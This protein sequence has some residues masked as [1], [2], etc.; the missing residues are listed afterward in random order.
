MSTY[1]RLKDNVL[2]RGWDKLPFCVVHSRTKQV[3]FVSKSMMRTL[4][5]C[6]GSWDFESIFCAGE[7]A[8]NAAELLELGIIEACAPESGIAPERGIAPEC[9]PK[10]GAA[11][12]RAPERAP[13]SGI[14]PERAPESG[15]A[16][17]G[18]ASERAPECATEIGT[19]PERATERGIAPE[20]SYRLYSNRFIQ[21][22]HWSITGRCNYRCQHC[23]MS[24]PDARYGELSHEAVM[25]IVRQIAE[26]GIFRVSLTG[27]E[28]LLR[29]DF[30]DIAGEL[31]RRDIA[32]TQL[33]TN[34]SLLTA[35]ILDSLRDM[36]QHPTVIMSFDGVGCHDWLRGVPGAEA[37]ANSALAL[38]AEKGFRAHAQ[39]VLHRENV[40]SLR[41]TVN[42]LAAAGCKSMRIGRVND[43]GDWVRNS[44]GRTLS[45]D[46]CRTAFLDYLPRYYEDGMPLQI[47][48]SGM[49]AASPEQPDWYSLPPGCEDGDDPNRL[50]F[51][52]ARSTMQLYADGRP[53]IC[54]DFGPDFV[55]APPVVSD[56]PACPTMPL[57]DQ[58]T[59]GSPYLQLFDRRCGELHRANDD[60]AACPY[61]R[62][63]GGGCRAAAR[64][65]GGSLLSKD[66]DT[67]SF[68][69]GGWA[70]KVVQ[71]MRRIRPEAMSPVSNDPRFSG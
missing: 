70:Q 64:Q 53:A 65:A 19:A 24:A 20:Q 71:T 37:A 38:C 35:E 58:L 6:D 33:Y 8:E 2:L 28:P 4:E 47:V 63:C 66:P 68:F 56:D 31:T 14:A 16:S 48:L 9:T 36:G 49:F 29:P 39:M 60:C 43:M 30:L 7:H 23:Y 41:E 12:K 34:G 1:Y 45:I 10:R 42:H 67:C 13:E 27:G 54:E 51:A 26:C 15:I 61:L 18:T 62:Y 3:R 50:L 32:I 55:G 40:Q 59:T 5:M 25:D 46:E 11:P 22:L 17:G 52:C 69:R 21:T 57:R 44:Q